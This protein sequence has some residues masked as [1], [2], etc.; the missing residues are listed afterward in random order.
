MINYKLLNANYSVFKNN[1]STIIIIY[2][3]NFLI[4]RLDKNNIIAIKIA[5][6]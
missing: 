4:I 5:L 1:A 3:N 6:Y 2:I